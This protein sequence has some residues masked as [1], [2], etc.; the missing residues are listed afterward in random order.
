MSQ[1]ARILLLAAAIVALSAL[2]ATVT[3]GTVAM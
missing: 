3:G 1:A 2:A